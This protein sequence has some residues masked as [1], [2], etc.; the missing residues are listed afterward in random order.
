MGSYQFYRITVYTRGGLELTF[1]AT[2]WRLVEDCVLVL[3]TG[4]RWDDPADREKLSFIAHFTKGGWDGFS[5]ATE[6]ACST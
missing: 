3:Y 1:A 4:G 2:D 6:V 5:V